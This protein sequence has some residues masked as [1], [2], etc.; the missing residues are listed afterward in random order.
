MEQIL[1]F[2]FR[3]FE[4]HGVTEFRTEQERNSEFE[5]RALTVDSFRASLFGRNAGVIF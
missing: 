2:L 4:F 1:Q 5:Q 3:R